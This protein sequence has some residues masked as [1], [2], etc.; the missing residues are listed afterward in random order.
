MRVSAETIYTY[1]Y[2]LSRGSLRKEL[3]GYLRQHRKKRR[4]RSR[5]V[6]RRGQI[7]EMISNYLAWI[8]K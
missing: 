8:L 1:L 7:L 4:P 3:L 5:G 6:D 2:V